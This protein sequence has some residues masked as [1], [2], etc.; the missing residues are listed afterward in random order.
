MT[1][2][3][4]FAKKL[5]QAS[6]NFDANTDRIL[7]RLAEGFTKKVIAYTPVDT[8]R[9]VSN[10]TLTIGSPSLA[11]K[12]PYAPGVK[13]S[14]AEAN[15]RAAEAEALKTART[16]T[17]KKQVWVTNATPY[18]VSLEGGSSKKAPQGM[19]DF[20]LLEAARILYGSEFLKYN[21]VIR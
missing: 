12:E 9:A 13:G 4:A 17:N 2:F 7:I 5:R 14:T 18:I 3:S 11:L 15:R 8:G 20:G 1:T 6:K 10:W 16:Y 19:I 21:G